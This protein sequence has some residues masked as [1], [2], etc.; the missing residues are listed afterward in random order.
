MRNFPLQGKVVL[1]QWIAND[2]PGYEG[3]S[4][5]GVKRERRRGHKEPAADSCDPGLFAG[6]CA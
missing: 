2:R 5:L 3:H 1:F 6:F 4:E